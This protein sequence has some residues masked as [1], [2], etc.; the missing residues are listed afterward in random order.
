M[1]ASRKSS[2]AAA[3]DGDP[4]R[5]S[6]SVTFS[7]REAMALRY[8]GNFGASTSDVIRRLLDLR[9]L[10]QL[11]RDYENKRREWE[12]QDREARTP[13]D[14]PQQGRLCSTQ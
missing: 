3:V 9:G 6:L 13:L 12:A 2:A 5:V 7:E 4:L 11:V 14:T 1:V 8:H 10:R